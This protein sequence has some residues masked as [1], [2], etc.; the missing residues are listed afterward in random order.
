M[1]SFRYSLSTPDST[2]SLPSSPTSIAMQD[3]SQSVDHGIPRYHL[4]PDAPPVYEDDQDGPVEA[5]PALITLPC[6]SKAPG[7][8]GVVDRWVREEILANVCLEQ[9]EVWDLLPGNKVIT[10][11][12]QPTLVALKDSYEAELLIKETIERSLGVSRVRVWMS[13]PKEKDCTDSWSVFLVSNITD[14]VTVDL[15]EHEYLNTSLGTIFTVSYIDQR[16]STY[17]ATIDGLHFHDVSAVATIP[18]V[19][20]CLVDGLAADMALRYIAFVSVN[21]EVPDDSPDW[22]KAQRKLARLFEGLSVE[23][24]MVYAG[25]R[26][27]SIF[28]VYLD[29]P[30]YDMK[31]HVSLRKYL[32]RY[33]KVVHPTRGM[34]R[35]VDWECDYC[36]SWKHPTPLCPV[37][38]LDNFFVPPASSVNHY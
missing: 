7:S 9:R 29:V 10:Y 23:G 8:P 2:R 32:R 26:P 6:N 31:S 38:R 14:T 12:W 1:K 11:R 3:F 34:G 35:C 15:I 33:A 24:T 28:H 20:R 5:N 21:I 19:Q 25:G 36:T 16:P 30:T 37:A 18:E 4:P 27:R 17:M 13:M 22:V